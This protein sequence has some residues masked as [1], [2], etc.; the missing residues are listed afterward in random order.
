MSD[1]I[2]NICSNKKIADTLTS[3]NRKISNHTVENYLDAI[4]ESLLMYRVF[5]YDIK[6]KQHL[7]LQEK[8]YLVDIGLRYYLLGASNADK[9]HIL[10]NIVY[11]ELLRR[12]YTIY[13]GKSDNEEVDFVVQDTLGNTEYYQVALTVRDESTLKREL[14]PLAN[15]QD[16]NTKYLLT[17]D[18]DLLTSHNGIKQIYVLDWLLNK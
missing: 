4:A 8:Y 6:G 17:M 9:G 18:N 14:K 10:E 13:V 11:L 12:G 1:N 5:R 16:H 15:I 2:G 7:Q 3:V